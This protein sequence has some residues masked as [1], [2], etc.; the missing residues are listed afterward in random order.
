MLYFDAEGR[1]HGPVEIVWQAETALDVCVKHPLRA[2]AERLAREAY[3]A[4]A[5]EIEAQQARDSIDRIKQL[6]RIIWF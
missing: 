6:F 4:K 5:A 3:K 2:E 1:I